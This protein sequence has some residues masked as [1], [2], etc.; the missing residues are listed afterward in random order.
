MSSPCGDIPSHERCSLRIMLV[1]MEFISNLLGAK[2]KEKKHVQAVFTM[3]SFY[4]FAGL[5]MLSF[6]N[7]HAEAKVLC[8]ILCFV[9]IFLMLCQRYVTWQHEK[10]N[11]PV[12]S[13]HFVT[14]SSTSRCYRRTLC[15]CLC[16][17]PLCH[18]RP[19]C[20]SSD[21]GGLYLPRRPRDLS[22][23]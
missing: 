20:S 15:L 2:R 12:F 3:P 11:K 21:F 4:L 5:L 16:Q 18:F 8:C 13:Q 7:F 9:F 22:L 14:L 17:L 10:T 1:P 19:R 6:A 23:Y